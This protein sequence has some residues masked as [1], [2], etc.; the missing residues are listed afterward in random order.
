MQ[1]A[2]HSVSGRTGALV[3]QAPCVSLIL[4]FEPKMS[5][6]LN[7][8][9]RLQKAITVAEKNLL[10]HYP[11][12]TVDLLVKKMNVLARQLEYST[13]KKSIVLNVSPDVQ[14]IF[15]LDIDVEE[16]I[17]IGE[18]FDTR[19]IVLSKRCHE[20]YLL[21]L[22][23]TATAKLLHVKENKH[24]LLINNHREHLREEKH[25]T[26]SGNGSTDLFTRRFIHHVDDGLNIILKAYPVPLVLACT[27]PAAESFRQFSKLKDSVIKYI[28]GDFD[29]G[30]TPQ[31]EQLKE[32]CTRDWRKMKEDYLLFQVGNA[33][34]KHKCSI[35]IR[36]AFKMASQKRGIKLVVEKNFAYP[37][38]TGNTKE[39]CGLDDP[40]PHHSVYMEDAVNEVIEKVLENSGD[41]EFVSDN[42]LKDY[43]HIALIH[44]Y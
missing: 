41:V 17:I 24:T 22:M 35:G 43:L 40:V 19:N 32:V 10:Q 42:V 29:Q 25:S 30:T 21:L 39:L 14:K 20:E 34:S 9:N 23:G 31:L 4:P 11:A 5:R 37:G 33:F 3:K 15:Y 1:T 44:Y 8:E 12:Y 28:P 16:K 27:E 7:L 26:Y 36:E 38:F 13:Y 2:I 6:R 18:S